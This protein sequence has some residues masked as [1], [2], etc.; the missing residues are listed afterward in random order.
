MQKHKAMAILEGLL[1]ASDKPLY[2]DELSKILEMNV[3]EV[4]ECLHSLKNEYLKTY[5][6]IN[7]SILGNR[8]RFTTKP[9]ISSYIEKFFKPREKERL[10]TA[11]LETLAIIMFQQPVTK[12]EIDSVRGVSSEKALRTLESK[13]LI[14]EYGRLDKPG[15]PILY[16]TTEDCLEY[17][18]ICNI[19]EIKSAYKDVLKNNI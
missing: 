2:I 17:F 6:G 7:I 3:K 15:R 9:E 18:G 16:A 11:A 1:F 4:L 5:H 14:C 13:N 10:S 19:E 8:V 12:V